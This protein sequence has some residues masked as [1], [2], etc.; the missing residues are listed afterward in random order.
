MSSKFKRSALGARVPHEKKTSGM[1]T[2]AMPLPEKI[3]LPMQQH[4]GAPCTPTVK[5]GDAVLVGTVVGAAGGFVGAAIHSGVSGTVEAVETVHMPNGRSVPAVVIRADGEQTPDPACVPP[6]V[7]DHA[8]LIA[9]VQAC[10]LV[11]LGGA[12]FPTA[13]KLSPKDLSAIDTLVINGAECEPYITSDNREFLEC[14]ESVMRG[15]AAVKQQL[16]IK[17]VVI[18]I[19]RNK[20]EAIDLMFSLVKNDPDYSVMPLQSRYPQG[21]EKVLIEKTTGRE[22]PRGGLPA[23]AG[24]ILQNVTTL[25]TLGKYLPTHRRRAGL[26]RRK[27]RCFQDPDGRPDDGDCR[28]GPGFPRAEAE[29][30]AGGFRPGGGRSARSRSVYPLRQLHQCLPHGPFAC[31]DRGRVHQERR[32]DAGQADGGPVHRLRNMQL[33][34]PGQAARHTDDESG[35]GRVAEK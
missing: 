1:A 23:D 13:V 26:L 19:E 18:G 14:S 31:G 25:S 8:S 35:Q 33:C 22:V 34:V 30:C 10:G 2:V 7:T 17:K 28:S 27:G 11:G 9:A 21:A 20:P 15:I 32:R 6:E 16:G 12:G 4:I 24:V 29:Q 3:V 5:K